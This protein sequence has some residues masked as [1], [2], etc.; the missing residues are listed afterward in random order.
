MRGV[1][2]TKL[3]VPLRTFGMRC[4]VGKRGLSVECAVQLSMQPIPIVYG[5][6]YDTASFGNKS[7]EGD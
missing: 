5:D 2:L 3:Q 6:K 4:A 1:L 7:S